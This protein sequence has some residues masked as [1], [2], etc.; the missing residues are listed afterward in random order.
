MNFLLSVLIVDLVGVA[1][2]F[3]LV[4]IKRDGW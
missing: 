3:M 4:L 1:L 2:Y